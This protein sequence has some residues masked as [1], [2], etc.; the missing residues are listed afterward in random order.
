MLWTWYKC[1]EAYR[2]SVLT[3][4]HKHARKS[5]FSKLERTDA[6]KRAYERGLIKP[7]THSRALW[8]KINAFDRL[9]RVSG[10]SRNHRNILNRRRVR[11]MHK[12]CMRI[13][14]IF[15]DRI[16]MHALWLSWARAVPE[17]IAITLLCFIALHETPTR[18]S[19]GA[20]DSHVCACERH[21][22]CSAS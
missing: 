14:S 20:A 22:H 10:G 1:C 5:R 16:C 7:F 4:Q 11:E 9:I 13:L 18:K 12:A 8:W 17:V 2:W 19:V 21:L 3:C 15:L 6:C